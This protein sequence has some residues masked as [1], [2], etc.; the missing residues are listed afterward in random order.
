MIVIPRNKQ[1]IIDVVLQYTG[2]AESVFDIMQSNGYKTL[3]PVMDAGVSL[4]RSDKS[5]TVQFYA[6]NNIFPS[7]LPAGLQFDF[8][9]GDFDHNNNDFV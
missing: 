2:T 4:T 8:D 6:Q 1:S 9:G 3:L 5:K 7:T